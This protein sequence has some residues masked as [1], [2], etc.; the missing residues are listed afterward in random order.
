MKHT[1][2]E[3]RAAM[4]G[5]LEALASDLDLREAFERVRTMFRT[6]RIGFK[7]AGSAQTGSGTVYCRE[8]NE[9]RHCRFGKKLQIHTR[10]RTYLYSY[11]R[12][13]P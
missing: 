6:T 5:I 3:G 10:V 9:G 8:G 11:E 13:S 12:I 4:D 7:A 2:R 1:E